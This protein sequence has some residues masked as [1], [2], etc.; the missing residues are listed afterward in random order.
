MLASDARLTLWN[1]GHFRSGDGFLETLVR[2]LDE[3]DFAILVATPDDSVLSR[4]VSAL[5]P[6]D[7]VLFELGLFMGRLGRGRTFL[8]HPKQHELRLPSDLLG[9]TTLS[10]RWPDATADRRAGLQDFMSALGAACDTI[11]DTINGWTEMSAHHALEAPGLLRCYTNATE[12]QAAIGKAIRAARRS[13][14]LMATNLAYTPALNVAELQQRILEGVD[15]RF[16]I[17][18]PHSQHVETT[19]HEFMIS[20]PQLREENR[21]H[22]RSLIDLQ[23]FS[24]AR[25]AESELVGGVQIRFYDAPPRM[26]CYCFDHQ[27]GTS[28]FVP[29]LNRTPSR[30]LP[31]FEVS[32]HGAIARRYLSS[33]E[34]LWSAPDSLTAETFLKQNPAYL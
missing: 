10:C 33:I 16:L 20:A 21:L 4:G 24:L 9:V 22:L 15:I 17:L 7:N 25:E 31:V 28:F 14:L 2:S 13:I 30:P 3:F 34:N 32:N 5:T 11:R 27:D 29:Y 12:A 23:H 19:A 18:N 1:E 8:V 6:R 26:R